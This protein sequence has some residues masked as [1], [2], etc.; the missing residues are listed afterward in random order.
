MLLT[1]FSFSASSFILF[2]KELVLFWVVI[3]PLPLPCLVLA[4]RCG[5]TRP[6]CEAPSPRIGVA[7]SDVVFLDGAGGGTVVSD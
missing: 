6:L 3:N 2:R 1:F 5:V 7:G 4:R